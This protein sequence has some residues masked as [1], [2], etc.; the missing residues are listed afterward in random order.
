[1]KMQRPDV[2]QSHKTTLEVY[3]VG[4][5]R[6]KWGDIRRCCASCR[7]GSRTVSRLTTKVV[8]F[9]SPTNLPDIYA[10]HLIFLDWK[11][12]KG[13]TSWRT[14]FM[15]FWRRTWCPQMPPPPHWTL[16]V[17]QPLRSTSTGCPLSHSRHCKKPSHSHSRDHRI[18][19][20]YRFKLYQ[21]APIKPSSL[22]PTTSQVY[23]TL[24]PSCLEMHSS[25]G[26]RFRSLTKTQSY[27]RRNTVELLR[28]QR[29]R[30]GRK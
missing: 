15:S 20:S 24:S 5:A 2:I 23:E 4:R 28:M 26:M 8:Q 10:P 19:I 14:I 21:T 6:W 22:P 18:Q 1:M 17:I 13:A 25:Y 3:L 7:S 29:W 12:C 27:F 11:T 9:L 16:K 30:S